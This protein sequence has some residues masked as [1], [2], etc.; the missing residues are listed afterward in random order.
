MIV[1]FSGTGNSRYVAQMLADRLSDELFDAGQAVKESVDAALHSEKPWVFVSPTYG[2]RIPRL[3]QAFL[4]ETVFSG[5]KDVYFVMTCGAEI[6]NAGK[7]LHRLSARLALTYRGVLQVVM[8]EN[9]LAM[10]SVP[11]RKR[12]AAIIRMAHPSI[13]RGADAIL[14][15]EDIP[16]PIP[17]V[18]DRVKSTLINPIFCRFLVRDRKFYTTDACIGCG[19][20]AAV[21][22]LHNIVLAAGKP[23]WQGNCT[24]CMA[25]ICSC[26]AEAIEYGK[27]SV[28]QP[29]YQCPPF[30]KKEA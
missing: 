30:E 21:C 22:P 16:E 20:C 25:C 19:K 3:F 1:Y 9:Y 13:C 11:D 24:H 6:G 10:F 12:A 23:Q 15:G 4:E 8:P 7:Y 5:S 18:L 27:K 17:G 14:H 26:P 28:G 2:W 29:R